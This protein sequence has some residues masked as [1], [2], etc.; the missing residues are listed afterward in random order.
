MSPHGMTVFSTR[1]PINNSTNPPMCVPPSRPSAAYSNNGVVYL[2]GAQGITN[3][4]IHLR[5]NCVGAPMAALVPQNQGFGYGNPGHNGA[6]HGMM[7][8]VTGMAIGGVSTGIG[9]SVGQEIFQGVTDMW[10]GGGHHGGGD[11]PMGLD[12]TEIMNSYVG[13]YF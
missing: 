5:P 8:G 11:G 6:N 9:E 3:Q 10:G 1:G 4:P 2:T 12:G 7:A 13:D